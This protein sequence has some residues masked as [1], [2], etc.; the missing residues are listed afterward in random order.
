[1]K[2]AF[3]WATFLAVAAAGGC[4]ESKSH[5]YVA[6]LY[7]PARDCL[8]PS[9]S[10]DIIQTG[11]AGLT[12]A[13]TCIVL[14]SPPSPGGEKVYVSTMCGPYPADYDVSGTDAT[15]PS[16]LAA[17]A[18]GPDVCN[19]DGTSTNPA[20]AGAEAGDGGGGDDGGGH[21]DASTSDTGAD[22][23]ASDAGAE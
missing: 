7:E 6:Q 16:A 22:A 12:C 17:F 5:V 19:S 8:D 10:L 13:P 11:Q 15:C 2:R 21:D 9:A 18:R 20:D 1:M 14:P 3:A 4:D 23:S